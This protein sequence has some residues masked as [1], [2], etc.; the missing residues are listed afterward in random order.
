M[1]LFVGS[2][3]LIF[4]SEPDNLKHRHVKQQISRYFRKIYRNPFLL[5]KSV[6]LGL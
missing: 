4:S 3:G 1:L 5:E 6:A 2:R